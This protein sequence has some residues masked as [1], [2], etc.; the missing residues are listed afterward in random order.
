[1]NLRFFVSSMTV[2]CFAFV[3]MA[4][5]A[6]A[7]H[8]DI[9]FGYDNIGNPGG[10][11]IENDEVTSDGI[12]FFESG[13]EI[14]DPIG[15]PGNYASDEPGYENSIDEGLLVGSGHQ[16]WINVLDASQHSQFGQGYINFYNP[17]TDS[18][19]A[20]GRLGISD[21]TAGTEDLILFGT[22]I[23]SGPNPQFLALG[24]D[25]Q[26]IG[27]Q[28]LDFDLLDDGTAP[29][30][31]YGVLLQLQSDFNGDGVFELSS[32]PY[33]VIFNRGLDERVFDEN[34]LAA[35]GAQEG[36]P[37]PSSAVLLATASLLLVR[38]RR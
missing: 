18:L 7:Q 2:T 22:G 5:I 29:L 16:I 34:A 38:R 24:G 28:H 35:F 13:F 31:A 21:N 27:D 23:E 26:T 10:F 1:M 9:E 4:N 11:I 14:F 37:E 20:N 15:S 32:D 33:W 12:Q 3:G 19:E 8:S 36:V 30:G 17:L 6:S 25:D